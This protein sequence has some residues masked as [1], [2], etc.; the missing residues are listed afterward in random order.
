MFNP[1][2]VTEPPSAALDTAAGKPSTNA[3]TKVIETKDLDR[4][5]IRQTRLS[6]SVNL[7][8]WLRRT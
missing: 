5:G 7:S 4:P 2:M 8:L 6:N 3:Q 1:V